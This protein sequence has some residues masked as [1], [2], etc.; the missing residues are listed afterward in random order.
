MPETRTRDIADEVGKT[1]FRLG[2]ALSDVDALGGFVKT[3]ADELDAELCARLVV[4]AVGWKQDAQTIMEEADAIV[5]LARDQFHEAD[6]DP[7]Y[8][9]RLTDEHKRDAN[10]W[11]RESMY[12][13]GG[14]S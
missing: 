5:K 14:G 4:Y 7:A 13:V 10:R 1:D 11:L 6:G 9:P 12:D 2:L 3:S 8:A